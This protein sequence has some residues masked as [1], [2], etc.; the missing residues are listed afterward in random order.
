MK[1]L[2]VGDTHCSRT[3]VRMAFDLADELA[4]DKIF[5]LGD[6]GF[7]P[8]F[9][10]GQE[11]LQFC[12]DEVKNTEIPLYF[13][14]G[15]HEDWSDLDIIFTTYA[16]DED[17][18]YKYENMRIAPRSH[19]WTWNDVIFGSMSGAFSIDWKGRTKDWDWFSQEVPTMKDV[20]HLIELK[21]EANI[22]HIDIMLAHD[23]PENIFRINGRHE[24]VI[25]DAIAESSQAACAE[26]LRQL[27][28]SFYA[29]GHWH[30]RI[31]YWYE[32]TFC[33]GLDKSDDLSDGAF[34][35]LTLTNDD[36]NKYTVSALHTAQVDN[37]RN[38]SQ[39]DVF[40]GH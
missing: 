11:F 35:L 18:F 6:F 37:V 36:E 24:W 29:H 2:L 15:N 5:Q 22:Q 1:I 9:D 3:A 28:P 10:N 34:A 25:K 13:L 4:C 32:E 33:Y 30:H 19:L 31:K 40:N 21:K 23:A 8:R 20:E 26:A 14:A 7:W 12:S 38:I 27:K 17:G 39:S 16:T